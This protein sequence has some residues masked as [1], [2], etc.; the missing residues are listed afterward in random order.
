M[1]KGLIKHSIEASMEV[2]KQNKPKKSRNDFFGL[3]R[4]KIVRRNDGQ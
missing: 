4:E 3:H 1:E 2:N